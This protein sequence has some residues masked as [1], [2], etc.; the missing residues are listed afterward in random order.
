[1]EA[2]SLDD[3]MELLD[4]HE[5]ADVSSDRDR[6]PRERGRRP[7]SAAAGLRKH[8]RRRLQSKRREEQL[9]D[10]QADSF[11]RSGR[12]RTKD[13]YFPSQTWQH[14]KRNNKAGR[15]GWKKWT[16]GAVLRS[17]FASESASSRQVASQ[18]DGAGHTQ[19][20]NCKLACAASVI[21][22]QSQA[23]KSAASSDCRI[24]IRS[25]MF[26]ESQ[27]DL[28]VSNRVVSAP[29]APYPVLCSHAQWT[30]VSTAG[31]GTQVRDEHICRPPKA[32]SV[33]NSANMFKVLNTGPGG[34][35]IAGPQATFQVTCVSSDAHSANIKLLK[36]LEQGMPQDHYI[37]PTLCAQ[38]RAGNCIEQVTKMTGLLG[39]VFCV[40]K[41]MSRG[42]P[43]SEVRKEVRAIVEEALLVHPSIPVAC[44]D[45]WTHAKEDASKLIDLCCSFDDSAGVAGA[46]SI[47]AS[48]QRLL[49][50]FSGPWTGPAVLHS[51]KLFLQ[52]GLAV[53]SFA[54]CSLQL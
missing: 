27:F 4:E 6:R 16:P 52:E 41:T 21:E 24:L 12:A 33:V 22:L 38:H 39:G 34:F 43:L 8:S 13:F 9:R 2:L 51:M 42:H 14:G 31:D 40:C 18:I 54:A 53:C 26:D 23:L 50:F 20:G 5:E 25:M 3:V 46:A 44:I 28:Q 48:F 10:L 45:E 37:V 7:R 19:A 49:A 36:F 47:Q 11:N 30:I 29:L 17:G 32:L 1:M 15:G 35:G